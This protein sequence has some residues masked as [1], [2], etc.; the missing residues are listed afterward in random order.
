[1]RCSKCHAIPMIGGFMALSPLKVPLGGPSG[2][3]NRGRNFGTIFFVVL[4]ISGLLGLYRLFFG[5]SSQLDKA[6]KTACR[7]ELQQAQ[8]ILTRLKEKK[9]EH[10]R[11]QDVQGLLSNR[12]GLTDEAAQSYLAAL[13]GGLSKKYSRIHLEEGRSY[14]DQLRYGQAKIEFR[15]AAELDPGS[16]EAFLGKG[17]C[18]KAE[19]RMSA[20]AE[21]FEKAFSIDPGMQEAKE[22]LRNTRESLDKGMRYYIFD[23]LGEPLARQALTSDGLGAKSYPLAA[24]TAQ[25]IGVNSEKFGDLG[26]EKYLKD[27]L[28]GNEVTLTIDIHVQDA[29][30]KAMGSKKGAVVVLNPKTGEIL[31]VQC[32][33]SYMPAEIDTNK[34]FWKIKANRNNPLVNRAFDGLFEPGS[35]CKIVTAAAA[36]ETHV[37]LSTLF[38]MNL[39]GKTAVRYNDKIFR[40]WRDHG[41]VRSLKE[42]MDVSSNIALRSEERRV[43]KECRCSCRSRWSPYH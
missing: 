30:N 14:M 6:V 28:P 8:A 39:S 17:Y 11:V 18:A 29:V 9:P 26:L 42:A 32:Q 23:S 3:R 12:Q 20:A 38:P 25:I 34:N 2:S 31:A 15:H 40:D 22:A 19:G 41:T 16:A 35:I 1:M 27:L 5:F 10:P 4:I 43:G 24:Q 33:P 7:G 37:D 21:D 36:L 13:H